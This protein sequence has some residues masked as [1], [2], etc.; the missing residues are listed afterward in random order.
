MVVVVMAVVTTTMLTR[1]RADATFL[2]RVL[3]REV[4]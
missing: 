1:N 3:E 2:Y 4:L